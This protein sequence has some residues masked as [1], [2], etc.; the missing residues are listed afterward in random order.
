M[1][2]YATC[3]TAYVITKCHTGLTTAVLFFTKGHYQI[4]INCIVS[5]KC[6][7]SIK[8]YANFRIAHFQTSSSF[9]IQLLL[10]EILLQAISVYI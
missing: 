6:N 5:L 4:C 10:N 9:P 3:F 1:S 8:D 7:M 2:A